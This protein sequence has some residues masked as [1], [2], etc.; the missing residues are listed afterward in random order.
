ME[1]LQ[2]ILKERN[3][4]IETLASQIGVTKQ[5]VSN[6]TCKRNYPSVKHLVALSKILKVPIEDLINY[7]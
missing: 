7:D 6:W 4:T 3:I 5:A 1:F 2:R